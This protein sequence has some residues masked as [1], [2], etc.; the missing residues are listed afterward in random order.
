MG[1]VVTDSRQALDD[2]QV[3]SIHASGLHPEQHLIRRLKGRLWQLL[4]PEVLQSAGCAQGQRL[5]G[6]PVLE[7]RTGDL[8]AGRERNGDCWTA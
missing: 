2:E 8:F 5:H 7:R 3:Q 4:Y 6:L 1:E